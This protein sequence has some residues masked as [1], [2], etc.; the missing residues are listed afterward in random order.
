MAF[1]RASKMNAPVDEAYGRVI[2]RVASSGSVQGLDGS[3]LAPPA[4]ADL[5]ST[6]KQ[7]STLIATIGNDQQRQQDGSSVC[8]SA[9]ASLGGSSVTSHYLGALEE[10]R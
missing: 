6:K 7:L 4:D 10:D 9:I 2:E 5:R 3:S 8:E 1:K